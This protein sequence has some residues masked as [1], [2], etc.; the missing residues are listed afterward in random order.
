MPDDSVKLIVIGEPA[1]KANSR[2]FIRPGLIIKSKK[3][4][5]YADL[6]RFQVK[7]LPSLIEGPLAIAIEINY[8]S[9]RPDLDPSLIFD[10]L[11]GLVYA[12]DRQLVEQHIFR[13]IDR[14]NPHARIAVWKVGP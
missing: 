1:S 6:F 3:A 9:M 13:G 8:A 2:R 11:Q 5:S 4:L 14:T 10:L 12:N 7:A